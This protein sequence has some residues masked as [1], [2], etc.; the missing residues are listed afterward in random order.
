MTRAPRSASWRVANGAAIACSSVT[1]VSP[2]SGCMLVSSAQRRHSVHRE[3]A[4][5]VLRPQLDR[6]AVVLKLA[7]DVERVQVEGRTHGLE[8]K[9]RDIAIRRVAAHQVHQQ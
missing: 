5:M 6:L 3:P 2:F 7:V 9:R 8:A 4:L 1:T